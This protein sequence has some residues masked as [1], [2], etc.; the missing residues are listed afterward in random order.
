MIPA[1]IDRASARLFWLFS[2]LLL[3]TGLLAV[4]TEN[5]YLLG[6]PPLLLFF[7]LSAV[8]FRFIFFLM[9]A[10]IPLSVEVQFGQTLGT[11]L[12]TEPLIAG[13]MLVCFFYVMGR[14][15]HIDRNFLK[16]PLTTLLLLHFFWCLVS[17][18]FS[19][20]LLVSVKNA[21]AKLWYITVFYFLAAMIV[22]SLRDF[23]IIFWCFLI[24]LL[25]TI[26]YT[27]VRHSKHHF[28]FD[29]VNTMMD[30]F[31]RNH[32]NYAVVLALFIPFVFA[33]LQWYHS[34]NV[35]LFLIGAIGLILLGVLL[36]YTRATWLALAAAVLFRWVLKRKLVLPVF[37]VIF[38]AMLGGLFYLM[39]DNKYLD[40]APDYKKTI[41]HVRFDE[42]LAST[43]HLQD[44][45]SA[46]RVYRW[47]AGFRMWESNPVTGFGPGNFYNFYKS[48]TVFKFRTYVS[49]NKERST[50]H[51]YFLLMLVEQGMVGLLL[52]I[53]LTIGLFYWGQ[54]IYHATVG[55]EYRALTLSLNLSIF[56]IY[57]HL[58]VNDL[59]ETVKI[60]TMLFLF[61]ALLVN[62]DLRNRRLL[63]E[64]P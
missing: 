37:I 14:S 2:I 9:M 13:L 46:E 43:T 60:G 48:Y 31:Y 53:A 63:K 38:I 23:K 40:L 55:R 34:R 42:H 20:D 50:V 24:P 18:I 28:T 54:R 45:S 21:T 35:R 7:Y 8:N 29:T 64:Q 11:D 36:S 17:T 62:Q 61:I 1:S 3:G 25:F 57:T 22:R 19:S 59:V 5:Y 6:V 44:I 15:S 12:P 51:N 26:V 4:Y 41:M 10:T 16:H 27:L 58:M 39:R 47:I 49:D 32:V 33:A 52:F 56:I 30:P